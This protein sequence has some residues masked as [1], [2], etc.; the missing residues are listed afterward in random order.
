MPDLERQM[1]LAAEAG[2]L[3]ADFLVARILTPLGTSYQEAVN[4]F[5]PY[6]KLQAPNPK[7]RA[8]AVKLARRGMQRNND[9]YIIVNNRCE[10]NAVITID[11]IGRML[12][13][14]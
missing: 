2:G 13:A 11:A 9:T 14:E 8:D 3:S 1:R 10:G 4:R 6:D 5:K 12:T 7:M